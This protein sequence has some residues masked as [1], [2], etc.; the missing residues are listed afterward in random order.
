LAA[1][2]GGTFVGRHITRPHA[3]NDYS[4]L[5]LPQQDRNLQLVVASHLYFAPLLHYGN[6]DVSD[7][8]LANRYIGEDASD[9]AMRAAGP[10]FHWPVMSYGE[11]AREHP[12]F[13]LLSSQPA[14]WVE[15]KL[16]ADG[17]GLELASSRYETTLYLVT[18]KP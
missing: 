5:Q 16:Q 1:I 14:N 10:F 7:S 9:R 8:D 6:P 15:Q 11:F 13:I 2:L 3:P 12:R 17:A 4:T 18:Q